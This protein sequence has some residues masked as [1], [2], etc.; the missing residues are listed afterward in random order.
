MK[1]TI[2]SAIRKILFAVIFISSNIYSQ[3]K[4][5]LPKNYAG[6]LAGIEWNTISGSWG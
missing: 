2:L 3:T 5:V 1:W 4:R 6:L